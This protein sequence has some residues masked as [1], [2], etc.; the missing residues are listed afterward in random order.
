MI[1]QL[2]KDEAI[3]Y[4]LLLLAD[5]TQEVIDRYIPD[6][7]LYVFEKTNQLLGIYAWVLID[8]DTFEIKNIAV[9][10]THQ[11]QGI[12]TLLLGDATKRSRL[13]GVK[14]LLIGTANTAFKQ[15]YLYQKEGF[16][17]E[18]IKKNFFIDNYPEPI[19][20]HGIRL[21]HMIMLRKELG[22]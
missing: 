10:E 1:R 2:L 20:E 19:Y 9:A 16:E 18:S 14:T 8:K 15:L 21:N 6:S 7:E 13:R 5:E 12:G 4:D 22:G 11:G 3:P 17:I